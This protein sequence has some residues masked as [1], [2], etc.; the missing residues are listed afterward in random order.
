MRSAIHWTVVFIVAG[1]CSYASFLIGCYTANQTHFS[2]KTWARH[3]EEA[4]E[5]V[6]LLISGSY[7]AFFSCIC[8]IVLAICAVQL[9]RTPAAKKMTYK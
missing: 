9:L 6:S 8:C 2:S 3:P 4:R 1:L 5:A 7:F